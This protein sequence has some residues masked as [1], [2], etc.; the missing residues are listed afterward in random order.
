[1][2][3]TS[4]V[5]FINVLQAAFTSDDPKTQKNT[6]KLSVFFALLGSACIKTVHKALV[7]LATGVNFINILPGHFLYKSLLNS[8]F[9]T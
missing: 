8:F 5:N 7:K 9:S 4:G 3:L 1:M 6:V 2:E